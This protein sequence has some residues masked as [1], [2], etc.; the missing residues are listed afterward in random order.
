MEACI[1]IVRED[2]IHGK[3]RKLEIETWNRK[4]LIQPNN[5]YKLFLPNL[6]F[7]SEK[8]CA[9]LL[10]QAKNKVC[11]HNSY[12][13]LTSGMPVFFYFIFFNLNVFILIGG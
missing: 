7:H 10:R 12:L 11:S 8:I 9:F 4:K 2:Y 13:K 3:G 1:L 5:I 6:V